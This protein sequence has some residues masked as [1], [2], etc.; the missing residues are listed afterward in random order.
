MKTHTF[1]WTFQMHHV[2]QIN[3]MGSSIRMT[4][5]LSYNVPSLINTNIEDPKNMFS[6]FNQ[7]IIV[8]MLT[9]KMCWNFK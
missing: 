3:L 6:L 5:Y 1:P 7:R 8:Q 9:L 2:N 4:S